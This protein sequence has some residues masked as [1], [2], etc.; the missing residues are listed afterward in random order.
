MHVYILTLL[1]WF[2]FITFKIPFTNQ[3]E[4]TKLFSN[5]CKFGETNPPPDPGRDLYKYKAEFATH[6]RK[7]KKNNMIYMYM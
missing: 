5:T 4:L 7:Y 6:K 2:K 1:K 3:A